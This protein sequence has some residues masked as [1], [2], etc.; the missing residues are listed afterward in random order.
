MLCHS[1]EL[2]LAIRDG[3]AKLDD[4][5]RYMRDGELYG[6]PI[7]Y[8][9]GASCVRL[10]AYVPRLKRLKWPRLGRCL[11]AIDEMN[12]SSKSPLERLEVTALHRIEQAMRWH[13]LQTSDAISDFLLSDPDIVALMKDP[14]IRREVELD[15]IKSIIV[16]DDLDW[17]RKRYGDALVDLILASKARYLAERDD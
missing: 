17:C 16:S 8:A 2:A 14:A 10:L 11:L 4:A 6:V 7:P 5:E 12:M 3:M 15:F 9:K 1:Y 13:K